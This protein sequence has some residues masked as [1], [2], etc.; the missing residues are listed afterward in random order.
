MESA[1]HL[2]SA[3]VQRAAALSAQGRLAR[4]AAAAARAETRALQGRAACAG[5]A[6]RPS[7]DI[8]IKF[9]NLHVVNFQNSCRSSSPNSS[10]C[11][12]R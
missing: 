9:P 11:S 4:K 10:R 8:Y 6:T 7:R 2:E 5:G 12:T 1:R 3:H